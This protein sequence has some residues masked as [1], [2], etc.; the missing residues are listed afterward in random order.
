MAEKLKLQLSFASSIGQPVDILAFD[1]KNVC[2]FWKVVLEPEETAII[3]YMW[4]K[5]KYRNRGVATQILEYVKKQCL[6]IKT[7]I[8]PS[9]KE[10]IAWLKKH[11]FKVEGEE[12]VWKKNILKP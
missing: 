9:T 12:L 5:R 6:C 4:T 3:Y 10:S 1:K 8:P 2:A 7:Q 11:D